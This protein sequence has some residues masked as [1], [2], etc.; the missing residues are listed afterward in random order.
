MP[1]QHG[2]LRAELIGDSNHAISESLDGPERRRRR[3]R[4]AV[5]REI[6][7][8]DPKSVGER[9][10][11]R[12]PKLLAAAPAMQEEDNRPGYAARRETDFW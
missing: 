4:N 9:P 8:N 10:N 12:T 2:V 3:S 1:D 7:R 11:L 5:A 6:N